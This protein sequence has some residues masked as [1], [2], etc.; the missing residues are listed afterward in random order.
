M[1]DVNDLFAQL[2]EFSWKGIAFPVAN[3]RFSLH[4]D[5]ARHLYP[6]KDGG[7]MEPTGRAPLQISA[8]ALFYNGIAP[9]KGETWGKAGTLYPAVYRKF[10][11]AC[12]D[13]TMGVLQHPEFGAIRCALESCETT[14]DS[15]RR[16]GVSVN[17][18]WI[19]SVDV[20]ELDGGFSAPSPIASAVSWGVSPAR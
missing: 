5:I 8:Q 11:T 16:D 12:S 7:H 20:D 9:G 15:G 1:A 4:H 2:L 19:E 3:V 10:M 6:D 18:S 14:L 17:A 13:R